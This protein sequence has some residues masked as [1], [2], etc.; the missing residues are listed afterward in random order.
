MKLLPGHMPTVSYASRAQPHPRTATRGP[1]NHQDPNPP[2]GL[3]PSEAYRWTTGHRH[4]E[5][6]EHTDI[7]SLDAAGRTR[8]FARLRATI[9]DL[10]HLTEELVRRRPPR[11][12]DGPS[13]VF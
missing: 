4:L 11:R 2:E 3:T 5:A 8:H 1:V 9:D 12:D 6:A 13:D 7:N 10:L